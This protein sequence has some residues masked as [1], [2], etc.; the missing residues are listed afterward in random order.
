MGKSSEMKKIPPRYCQLFQLLW[1]SPSLLPDSEDL[2][3]SV[4]RR[5]PTLAAR[6]QGG[7]E[8]LYLILHGSWLCGPGT[9]SPQGIMHFRG[10]HKSPTEHQPK[11]PS[12][13]EPSSKGIQWLAAHCW[14]ETN[15]FSTIWPMVSLAV[16]LPN[17]DV[18]CGI[19]FLVAG[20]EY[21]TK[22][23]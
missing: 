14:V 18:S 2:L 15:S 9:T 20:T 6:S 12:W 17:C 4:K 23:T 5:A 13:E 11:W 22:A 21:P 7:N 16:C 8:H 1:G 19:I 10:Q 3:L